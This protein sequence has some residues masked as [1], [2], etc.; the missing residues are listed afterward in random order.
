MRRSRL[1]RS[2][3]RHSSNSHGR[4]SH[5]IPHWHPPVHQSQ[6]PWGEQYILHVLWM[7]LGKNDKIMCTQTMFYNEILVSILHC[8]CRL[9]QGINYPAG[10]VV[11][12]GSL[13]TMLVLNIL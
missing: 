4:F 3:F 10:A 8:Y 9:L 13:S 5:N 12:Q 2:S 6:A 1:L 11:N 7:S